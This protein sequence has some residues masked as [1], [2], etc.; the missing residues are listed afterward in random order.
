M[1]KRDIE[2]IEETR[3]KIL[4]SEGRVLFVNMNQRDKSALRAYMHYLDELVET[5]VNEHKE[6]NPRI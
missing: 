1:L 2:Y 3:N 4:I 6:R 5:T